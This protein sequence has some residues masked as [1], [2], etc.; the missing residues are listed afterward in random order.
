MLV[1]FSTGKQT[2]T[3]DL[4]ILRKKR[5]FSSCIV[6]FD[7]NIYSEADKIRKLCSL[8]CEYICDQLAQT[9]IFGHY[10]NGDDFENKEKNKNIKNV[11]KK[12]V[13]DDNS[14]ELDKLIWYCLTQNITNIQSYEGDLNVIVS[15]IMNELAFVIYH[16]LTINSINSNNNS[17][18]SL[19]FPKLLKMFK[20]IYNLS[21]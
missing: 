8:V 6:C 19:L 18:D 20:L 4:L 13:F 2:H 17:K 11:C 14:D 1:S 10:V 3:V 12:L 21:C 9:N 15:F 5:F 16:D 7:G